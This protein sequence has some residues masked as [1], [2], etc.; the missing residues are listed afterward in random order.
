[1]NDSR[2]PIHPLPSSRFPVKLKKG[3]KMN[4]TL[5]RI[6]ELRDGLIERLKFAKEFADL[7]DGGAIKDSSEKRVLLWADLVAVLDDYKR[8]RPLL[9]A[10][11]K[12]DRNRVLEWLKPQAC[13][14]TFG[15]VRHIADDLY[16]LIAALPD[17]ESK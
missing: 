4:I 8:M 14:K 11:E 17:K 6:K 9:E 16:D 7:F 3:V 15:P 2:K 1:M 13:G 10:V 5:K 12:V